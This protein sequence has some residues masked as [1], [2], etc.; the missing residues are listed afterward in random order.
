MSV[1][2]LEGT[3][4]N[5]QVILPEGSTLPEAAK[6]YVLVPDALPRSPRVWSPRLL[7][8]SKLADLELE[9]SDIEDE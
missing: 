1:T 8:K 5:G 7:D 4:K 3:V 9:V 6:V 2:T